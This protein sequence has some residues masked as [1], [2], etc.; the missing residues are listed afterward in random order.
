MRMQ[1]IWIIGGGKFGL[2]AARILGDAKHANRLTLVERDPQKCRRFD[3]PAGEI[4]CAEGIGYLTEHLRGPGTADWIVPAIPS[5]VAYEWIKNKLAPASR[6]LPVP[7]PRAVLRQF[8][9]PIEGG[10]GQVYLSDADFICPEDCPEPVDR[11]TVTGRPR[12]RSLGD[13]LASIRHS[14]FRSVVV[15]SHQLAPGVGGMRS[16]RLFEILC[17]IGVLPGSILLSTA[18]RCHGVT[19]AFRLQPGP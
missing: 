16:E 9:N 19:N 17:E 8:P 18:C 2:R 15:Q 11:C 14:G 7:I 12:G 1:K 3:R 4:V 13:R 10:C 5:H 6:I